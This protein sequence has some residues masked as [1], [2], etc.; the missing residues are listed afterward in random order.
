P[1]ITILKSTPIPTIFHENFLLFTNCLNFIN[2]S[3]FLRC[4]IH[5]Y[6]YS[7]GYIKCKLSIVPFYSSNLYLQRLCNSSHNSHIY[8]STFFLHKAGLVNGTDLLGQS[9]AV[10]GK[11]STRSLRDQHMGWEM[12]PFICSSRQRDYCDHR[13]ILI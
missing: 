7:L 13:G 11:P 9:H 4:Q 2:N 5:E 3:F 12:G 6:Y 1:K 10:S 8:D